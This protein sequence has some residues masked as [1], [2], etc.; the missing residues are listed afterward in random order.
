MILE[1]ELVFWKKVGIVLVWFRMLGIGLFV[2]F[3]VINEW[4]LRLLGDGLFWLVDRDFILFVVLVLFVKFF[5]L[6]F[7]WFNEISILFLIM[8]LNILYL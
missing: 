4:L 2:L 7:E 6:L 8:L 3:D 5:E 1:I